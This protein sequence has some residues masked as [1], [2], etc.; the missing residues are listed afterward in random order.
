MGGTE[1][2]AGGWTAVENVCQRIREVL[3]C[4]LY[5][6]DKPLLPCAYS[7]VCSTVKGEQKL[8]IAANMVNITEKI[9]EYVLSGRKTILTTYETNYSSGSRPKWPGRK[10]CIIDWQRANQMANTICRKQSDRCDPNAY[11]NIETSH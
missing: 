7:L 3:A 1:P 4:S 11:S 9:K 6:D 2:L 8:P 10:V 5:S